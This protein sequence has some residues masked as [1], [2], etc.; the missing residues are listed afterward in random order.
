M[1]CSLMLWS[2]LMLCSATA[3]LQSCTS[4][5]LCDSEL[6]GSIAFSNINPAHSNG[7]L[8]IPCVLNPNASL[9]GG[10]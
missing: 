5:G 6:D 10:R 8:Y 7:M 4:I 3:D 9:T 1:T 2:C